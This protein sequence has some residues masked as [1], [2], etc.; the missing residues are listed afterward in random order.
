MNH[1]H[2][3]F[4]LVEVIVALGV[5]VLFA[6][7]IY[8]GIQLV[9]KV[10]YAS[11]IRIL[12][13]GILN[14]QVEI[15]RN[16]AYQDIGIV[17]GSPAGVLQRTVTTTRNGIEF[18]ITRTIRSIDDP[19]DGTIGGSPND[20]APGDYK[21]V[22]IEVICT[23]CGQRQPTRF[24]SRMG[25]R[26]L[27]SSLNNGALFI[28][29]FDA[30]AQ[31]VQ[32]AT[33]SILATSTSSTVN[34]TDT[35]DNQGMLRLVDLPP[36]IAAYHITTTKSGYT[37]DQTIAPSAIV[38][39]PVK[40]PASVVAQ[41]VS[42]LSFSIDQISS[43]AMETMNSLC[44]PLPSVPVHILGT[45]LLGINPDVFIVN[46]TSTT[47]VLGRYTFSNL[48]W[49]AYGFQ[50]SGYD[51]LGS[52]PASPVG[53]GPGVNQ[54]VQLVLGS[55]TNHSLIVAVRDGVTGQ[56][57]SNAL[58]TVTSTGYTNSANTGVGF[59]H[60]T[61]WAGGGGQDTMSDPTR[62][63]SD[64]GNVSVTSP[65]GDIKLRLVGS[66]YVAEGALESSTFDFGLLPNYVNLIWDPLA[67]APETGTSSIRFQLATSPLPTSTI[68]TYR[69][70]DGAT[71][72]YY[73]AS[74]PVIFSGHNG[75]RYLRYK[76]YLSTN[77]A[78]ATPALS[79]VTVTY[80]NQCTP[81]G[82]V[83]FGALANQTYAV[84][85]SKNGYLTRREEITVNGDT[86]LSVELV[87]S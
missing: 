73:T 35:T 86:I 87:S 12:E 36:G 45:K 37:A 67:Q 77:T 34:L 49:D 21:L 20:T 60:Q 10:V 31:P 13:T 57:L 7:G 25:P 51:L 32:G 44:T 83:Y 8:G 81:P 53:L 27:E 68:W 28:Q 40:P 54:P 75:D 59:V 42:S 48:V 41:N 69:G 29:V 61:D 76:A 70:P 74:T 22:E 2:K 43:I 11:R 16:L 18:T 63:W 72:T 71:S 50:P 62:Y 15:A 14:E 55:N 64:D 26:Y 46:S 82:Q 24:S 30:Q 56:P 52:I 65:S 85:I 80:T 9:F 17:N 4:S 78:T 79:S 38:A 33:V 1:D 66:Q 84:T 6:L 5:F 39:N 23:T 19:Y 58:V 3:G 47:D